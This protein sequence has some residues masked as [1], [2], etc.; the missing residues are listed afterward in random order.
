MS[1]NVLKCPNYAEKPAQKAGFL[2]SGYSKLIHEDPLAD[3]SKW[4]Y[5]LE[6]HVF[7][8]NEI[9]PWL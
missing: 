1:I 3:K 5:F 9:P 2:F 8:G 7:H 6:V 4:G